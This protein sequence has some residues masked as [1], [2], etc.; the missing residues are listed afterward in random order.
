MCVFW[1]DQKL[2]DRTCSGLTAACIIRSGSQEITCNCLVAV[3]STQPITLPVHSK[4]EYQ[5]LCTED[6]RSGTAGTC[7]GYYMV[8]TLLTDS[9]GNAVAR[10]G[11]GFLGLGRAHGQRWQK[12]CVLC[13]FNFS[14]KL[15]IMRKKCFHTVPTSAVPHPSFFFSQGAELSPK[16][17]NKTPGK[18]NGPAGKA[19]G[20]SFTAQIKVGKHPQSSQPVCFLFPPDLFFL[21]I[22]N[23]RQSV[24][25]QALW[26]FSSLKWSVKT[27][28]T[29]LVNDTSWANFWTLFFA[30]W[31]RWIVQTGIFF[32]QKSK[33]VLTFLLKAL[34]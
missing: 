27:S 30:L 28:D 24:R 15:V 13:D 9:G 17:F 19:S 16:K 6:W 33:T 11:V 10:Q 4:V 25:S 26:V 12:L 23:S 21:S 18:Q 3:L 5:W 8:I 7:L 2:C 1:K 20:S 14:C 34:Q 22:G 31:C 29:G 32:T